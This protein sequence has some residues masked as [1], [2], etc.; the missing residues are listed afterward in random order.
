MKANRE[1]KAK[2]KGNS[3]SE[4]NEPNAKNSMP[5]DNVRGETFEEHDIYMNELLT[6]LKTIDED[7]ITQD[8]FIYVEKHVERLVKNE[9]WKEGGSKCGQRPHRLYAPEKGKQIKYSMYPSA[10]RDE[11][12]ACPW[13]CYARWITEEKTFQCI[14]LDDEQTCVRNFNLAHWSTISGLETSFG[15]KIKAYP[16]IRLCD[17]ADLVLKK[18]K[19][20]VSVSVLW[21]YPD[22]NQ[23]SGRRKSS[24]TNV[25]S[26]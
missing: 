15:D 2:A 1:A 8:P 5:A 10:S 17:I 26:Q 24:C 23:F 13:R 21:V 3:V 9:F 25:L 16:D 19:C 14:S 18:Y 7:R 11:L 20:K 22:T 6:R 4:I 12:P